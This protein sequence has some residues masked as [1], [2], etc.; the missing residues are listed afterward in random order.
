MKNKKFSSIE[1]IIKNPG[2]ESDISGPQISKA[3]YCVTLVPKTAPN[4]PPALI[5][6]NKRFPSLPLKKLIKVTQ[7]IETTNKEYTFSQT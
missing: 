6:P 2:P 3:K 1:N 7:K 5:M 4:D